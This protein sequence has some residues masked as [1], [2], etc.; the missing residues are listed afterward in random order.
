MKVTKVKRG[1]PRIKQSQLVDVFI[2]LRVTGKDAKALDGLSKRCNMSRSN[3]VRMAVED[4]VVQIE[5]K[6]RLKA[7]ERTFV[8]MCRFIIGKD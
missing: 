8:D 5:R 3:F 6:T 2:S 1:R 4:A 7:K